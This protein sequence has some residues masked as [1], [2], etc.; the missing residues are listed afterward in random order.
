MV[1][2][3]T[4]KIPQA[5]LD[6]PELSDHLAS[7]WDAFITLSRKRFN[8]G[9]AISGI[10]TSEITAW[11]NEMG[12]EEAEDRV[13]F[14]DTINRMDAVFMAICNRKAEERNS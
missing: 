10:P 5:L 14:M 8:S 9:Y 7:F 11:M 13:D 2:K 3:R 1:A 12:I 4:G 6:A